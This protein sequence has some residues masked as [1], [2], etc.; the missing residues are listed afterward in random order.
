MQ[1]DVARFR[2]LVFLQRPLS[3]TCVFTRALRQMSTEQVADQSHLLCGVPTGRGVR[4][5]VT[6]GV[7]LGQTRTGLSPVLQ[8]NGRVSGRL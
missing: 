1:S 7:R 5:Q 3:P 4:R 8:T 2:P 6:G